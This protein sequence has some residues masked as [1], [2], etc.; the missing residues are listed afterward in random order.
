MQERQLNAH[1]FQLDFGSSLYQYL[2]TLPNYFRVR[3]SVGYELAQQER[4]Y[5]KV[6]MHLKGAEMV[7]LVP[8]LCPTTLLLQKDLYVTL[9]YISMIRVDTRVR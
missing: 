9:C 3:D 8:V 6:R 1:E 7:F 4:Y 2:V 5:K